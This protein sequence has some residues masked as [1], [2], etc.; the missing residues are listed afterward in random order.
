MDLQI[1]RQKKDWSTELTQHNNAFAEDVLKKYRKLTL[2]LI[3]KMTD[4]SPLNF[5]TDE[6]L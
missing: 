1:D 4:Y 3:T 5:N 2:E 6:N